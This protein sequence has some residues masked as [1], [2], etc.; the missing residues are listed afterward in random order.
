MARSDQVI[1][2]STSLEVITNPFGYVYT[3]DGG[4]LS[5]A[6]PA[7]LNFYVDVKARISTAPTSNQVIAG[8]YYYSPAGAV[9]TT[10][11][12]IGIM[13]TGG[14]V[15]ASS[16]ANVVPTGATFRVRVRYGTTG[17]DR[18]EL[19]VT[20]LDGNTPGYTVNGS[21]G[22]AAYMCALGANAGSGIRWDDLVIYTSLESINDVRPV[23]GVNT[24]SQPEQ[25]MWFAGSHGLSSGNPIPSQLTSTSAGS[26]KTLNGFKGVMQVHGNVAAWPPATAP[27]GDTGYY[28]VPLSAYGA[29]NNMTIS[30]DGL[31]A[32]SCYENRWVEF[33]L[34]VKL[35]DVTS[36]ISAGQSL[37]LIYEGLTRG[38]YITYDNILQFKDQS[39]TVVQSAAGFLDSTP[40]WVKIRAGMTTAGGLTKI[41]VWRNTAN[42]PAVYSDAPDW[43][44]AFSN[45]D[46]SS[47]NLH[48]SLPYNAPFDDLS[49]NEGAL[50]AI[51]GVAGKSGWGVVA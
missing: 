12:R 18:V 43:E 42:I 34:M 26:I 48:F 32:A 22:S 35:A 29:T 40:W 47:P 16:A 1:E 15:V 51:A 30:E 17:V 2:G 6:M 50:P 27:S 38:L 33:W 31:R 45:G 3:K 39:G 14:A 25:S 19:W 28:G 20:D 13:D 41:Q 5:D 4:V 46:G 23:G 24:G 49:L 11:R 10:D 7:G 44:Q 9:I 37:P 36:R 21:S 8:G